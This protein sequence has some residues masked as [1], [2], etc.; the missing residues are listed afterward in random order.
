MR[1]A[2]LQLP[3]A[4]KNSLNEAEHF[5]IAGLEACRGVFLEAADV[6][7]IAPFFEALDFIGSDPGPSPLVECEDLADV[8][9]DI[10][11][12]SAAPAV[13]SF[14]CLELPLRASGAT[15]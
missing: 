7:Q 13:G 12:A 6:A 9:N 8:A 5:A 4:S 14:A 15:L 1:H 10:R 2:R 3:A 11:A